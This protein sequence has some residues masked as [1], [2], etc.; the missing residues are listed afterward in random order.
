MHPIE[1]AFYV[2]GAILLLVLVGIVF[3]NN[4]GRTSNKMVANSIRR[5]VRPEAFDPLDDS[6]LTDPVDVPINFRDRRVSIRANRRNAELL[7]RTGLSAFPNFRKRMSGVSSHHY[8]IRPT[9]NT[10]FSLVEF[11]IWQDIFFDGFGE[12]SEGV[13]YLAENWA[14]GE[15]IPTDTEFSSAVIAADEGSEYSVDPDY[16]PN[17]V[18]TFGDD[19]PA[20]SALLEEDSGHSWSGSDSGR[21][22]DRGGSVDSGGYDSGGDSGRYDSG[23]G[24]CGGD[25]CDGD[26][27]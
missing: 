16:D 2:I 10:D 19:A 8:Y 14:A 15:I 27:D 25:D 23:G 13:E 4:I 5:S 26:F 12:W 18:V 9:E 24:D 1:I 21:D 11:L 20:R 17:R 7:K 3:W 6:L 22:F